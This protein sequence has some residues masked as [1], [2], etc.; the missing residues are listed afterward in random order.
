MEEIQGYTADVCEDSETTVTV[1]AARC[2]CPE[3]PF[4]IC[5]VQQ[6]PHLCT[7]DLLDSAIEEDCECYSF[8]DGEFTTC[9]DFPGGLLNSQLCPGV[10]V[11]GCNRARVQ[12]T[13]EL[14]SGSDFRNRACL[15]LVASS[16]TALLQ[17]FI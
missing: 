17:M 16:M 4:P 2:D 12:A 1:S 14:A 13:E 15:L 9:Y 8:C 7:D 6:N 3:S 11:S 10:P 5:S